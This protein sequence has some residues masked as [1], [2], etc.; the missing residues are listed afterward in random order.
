VQNATVRGDTRGDVTLLKTFMKVILVRDNYKESTASYPIT[1]ANINSHFLSYFSVLHFPANITDFY[2][3]L[4][5][6]PFDLNFATT[7]TA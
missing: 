3:E 6:L 7:A 5:F 4:F 2:L 1:K